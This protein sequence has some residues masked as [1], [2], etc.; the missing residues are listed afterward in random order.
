MKFLQTRLV[1]ATLVCS[2]A[3]QT[4]LN[5]TAEQPLLLLGVTTND[6][7]AGVG[8]GGLLTT[9]PQKR[10]NIAVLNAELANTGSNCFIDSQSHLMVQPANSTIFLPI[11][12]LSSG[13]PTRGINAVTVNAGSGST[14]WFI[15][16]D[17]FAL[18]N[19]D[20]KFES[21]IVCSGMTVQG[22][23]Q[24]F[25]ATTGS[26]TPKDCTGVSS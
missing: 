20:R 9:A 13:G 22:L 11:E 6:N 24:L 3:A 7:L 17:N 26:K 23:A 25:W 1:V 10:Q 5:G 14:G 21:F 4:P 18:F 16:E 15:S 8:G 12:L 2:A 19:D